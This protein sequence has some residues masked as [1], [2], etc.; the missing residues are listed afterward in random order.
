MLPSAVFIGAAAEESKAR[1]YGRAVPGW[2]G[3][4][5]MASGVGPIRLPFGAL[6]T[7]LPLS[8]RVECRVCGAAV[9]GDE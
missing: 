6:S 3:A 1:R 8:S 9:L 7:G 5:T 2:D 4:E